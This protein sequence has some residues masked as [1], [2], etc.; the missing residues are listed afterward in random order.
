M[1]AL[2]KRTDS[3]GEVI[4][5]PVIDPIEESCFDQVDELNSHAYECETGNSFMLI[6]FNNNGKWISIFDNKEINL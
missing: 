3:F 6:A 1:K 5:F 2:V 4:Y